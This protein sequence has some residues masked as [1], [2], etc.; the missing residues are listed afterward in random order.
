M[1][2]STDQTIG[3]SSSGGGD[4]RRSSASATK[5][6]GLMS[7]KRNSSDITAAARKAS[8]AEQN[9]KPGVF[10]SM[11]QSFTRGNGK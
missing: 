10:G 3:M 7:Q 1:S 11:W 8:F 5:F 4:R 9:S 2:S 6:A